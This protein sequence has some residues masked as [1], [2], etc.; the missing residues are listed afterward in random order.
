MY[1]NHPKALS[2]CICVCFEVKLQFCIYSSVRQIISLLLCSTEQLRVHKI[3]GDSRGNWDVAFGGK[4]IDECHCVNPAAWREFDVDLCSA[5]G[6]WRVMGTMVIVLLAIILCANR[7]HC[8]MKGNRFNSKKGYIRGIYL[9]QCDR[10]NKI[11]CIQGEES[12]G[13]NLD[14]IFSFV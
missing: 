14:V 1:I 4:H 12:K 8:R 10:E 13:V 3:D 7:R 9:K 6:V 5:I 2:M 11:L